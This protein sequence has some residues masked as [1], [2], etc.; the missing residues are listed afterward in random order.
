MAANNL[1]SPIAM[2]PPEL[3]PDIFSVVARTAEWRRATLRLSQ[4]SQGFR[5]TVLDMSLLFTHADWDHWALPL[6]DLW[7]RRARAQLS[8]FNLS[9]WALHNLSTGKDP[10]RQALLESLSRRWGAL[11]LGICFL[12]D[13]EGDVISLVERL[14]QCDCPALHT[15]CLRKEGLR[16]ATTIRLQLDCL[17]SLRALHLSAVVPIFSTS[18]VSVAELAYH[19]E[20]T[21]DWLRCLDVVTSC[22]LIQRLII[23][24][25]GFTEFAGHPIEFPAT[26]V[27]LPSLTR[28][29]LLGS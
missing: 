8:T 19:C 14:L 7:C 25:R 11:D 22:H 4:V 12:T 13:D 3:M 27:V 2:L 28:I 20:D 16:K 26:R 23:G 6:L 10:E 5:R 15:L 24:K 1:S 9:C 29:E 17:P 21:E 18:P